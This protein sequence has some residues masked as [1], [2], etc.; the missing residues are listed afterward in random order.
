MTFLALLT[1]E[2]RLTMRRE[3]TVWLMIT[4]V[5]L[6][7]LVGWLTLHTMDINISTNWSNIGPTLY[8]LLLIVQLLLVLFITPTFTAT[9]INGEKERQTF[10]L[11]LCSRLSPLALIGGKLLSGLTN[12]L[13]L[14]AA[15]LPLFSLVFFFGGVSP[16]EALIA[17]TIFVITA[18]LVATVG[19]FCSTLVARPAVST[20][21][22]YM[23]VLLW[24]GLPLLFAVLYP[25]TAISTTTSTTFHPTPSGTVFTTQPIQNPPPANYLAWSPVIALLS[26]FNNTF[27]LQGT[28]RIFQSNLLAWQIYLVISILVSALFFGASLTLVKPGYW[29]NLRSFSNL[30]NFYKNRQSKS[31]PQQEIETK[32]PVE[33]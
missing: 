4:Y 29:S 8:T 15:S 1:K 6:L 3:R 26:S 9:T 32:I 12:S 30:R 14:I 24:L 5:L 17:L 16:V 27:N 23:L 31:G 2:L 22:A 13:L 28:Y 10:D 25:A 11:L 33:A 20:A 19:I 21:L 18:L 7:G